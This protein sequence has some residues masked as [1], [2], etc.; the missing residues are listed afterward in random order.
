V[1]KYA[2]SFIIGGLM[3]CLEVSFAGAR[4][5]NPFIIASAPPAMD[6]A[7]I[8]RAAAAGWGGAV[9][10][11][12]TAAAIRDVR[13]RMAAVREKGVIGMTNIELISTLGLRQWVEE[14]IPAVKNNCPDDF[15]LIASIMAGPDP[16]EWANLASR[17][18]AAGAD[19]IELNVSCPHGMP[20]KGMGMSIGQDAE[21]VEAVTKGAKKGS[22]LPVIVKLTPNVTDIGA[23]AAAAEAGG[24]DAVA[25][26]NTVASIPSVD[27]ERET[28]LP[29]V[30]GRS[31]SGGLSG[32]AIRPIALRCIADIKRKTGLPVSGIGGITDWRS[33][34]EFLL[35]GASTLQL[36]TAVMFRGFGLIGELVDGLLAYMNRKG[37]ERISDFRGHALNALTAHRKLKVDESVRAHI[38][39]SA[40]SGCGAC[41]TACGDGAF[42]AVRIENGK[43]EV[44]TALCDGCGLCAALCP[45]G[46][47][48]IKA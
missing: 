46:A 19:M 29:D 18:E 25:G 48:L 3:A 45:S 22:S 15:V 33:A 8:I 9:T 42:G 2:I 5:R 37:Y 41:V 11:T 21:L 7:H 44:D 31:T 20:E 16:Q 10:K 39:A 35:M 28:P 4:F 40:C 38:S 1:I 34:V 27:I 30:F 47:V 13:P 26:I 43:A 23:M 6:A 36:G 17:V 32:A 24:A 14:E 12:I